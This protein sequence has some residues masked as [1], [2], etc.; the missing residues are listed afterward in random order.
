V[1]EHFDGRFEIIK[2]V[3]RGPHL[4]ESDLAVAPTTTQARLESAP[5]G[6]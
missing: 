2:W 1:V 6:A 4:D 5:G 3:S